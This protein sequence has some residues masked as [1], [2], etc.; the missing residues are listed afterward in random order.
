MEYMPNN[1]VIESIYPITSKKT[2]MMKIFT[3]L[4]FLLLTVYGPG[5]LAQT[6]LP[7][8][9]GFENVGTTTTFTSATTNING[10]SEWSYEKTANGRVRFAA[11]SAY[12]R[13]GSHAAT[14]DCSRNFTFSNNFLILTLDLDAYK[15]S[16][17]ELDFYF[18][19][20]GDER[21]NGQDKVWVR[22]SNTSSWVQIYD[23]YA[24]RAGNGQWK[25]SGSLDIDAVLSNANQT[26]GKTFQVRFGQR[27]NYQATSTTA[28]DGLTI[29]DLRIVEVLDRNG[30]I[31]DI[32]PFCTGTSPVQVELSNLGNNTITSAKISWWVDGVAQAGYTFTGSVAKNNTANITLGNYNFSSTSH[33]FK[34]VVDSINGLVDQNVKDTLI[35]AKDPA[36]SGAFTVGPN[37]DFSTPDRAVIAMVDRGICGPVSFTIDY[38]TYSGRMTIPAING[39]SSTN[40]ITFD[41][42]DSSRT[43]ITYNAAARYPTLQIN[44]GEYIT[45]KNCRL[46]TTR[47]TDGWCAHVLGNSHHISFENCWFDMPAQNFDLIG[48]VLS[49]S[50]TSEFTATRVSHVKAVNSRFTGGEK[51]IHF[52]GNTNPFPEG[53]SAINNTF[54][55]FYNAAIDVRN[56]DSFTVIGNHVTST[57]NANGDGFMFYDIDDFN[58]SNNFISVR[59]WGLYINDANFN[60]QGRS[61]LSNNMVTAGDDGIYLNDI[62]NTDVWHNTAIGRPGILFDDYRGVDVRNNIFY[63][64]NDFALSCDQNFGFDVLDYNL[65]YTTGNNTARYANVNYTS[66]DAWRGAVT[67]FNASS[68]E[69]V[70]NI[71]SIANPRLSLLSE[72]YRGEYLAAVSTDIDGDSRCAFAPSLGADE[73]GFPT[74]KTQ[75]FYASP[76]TGYVNSSTSFDNRAKSTD[77]IL[78]RWLVDG[79]QEAS[80]TDF[81]YKFASAGTYIVDLIS[82]GCG[83]IDTFS[84]T[85]VITIPSVRPTAAFFAST[86]D[87]DVNESVDFTNISSS[88]ADSFYWV[89]DSYWVTG[90][91]GLKVKSH[92]FING[93]DS[94]SL[95]PTIEFTSPG[96]YRICLYAF[97]IRGV[98][99]VCKAAHINVRQRVDMCG[100]ADES[101]RAYGKL[102]DNGGPLGNYANNLTCGFLV[103]PCTDEITLNFNDFNLSGGDFLRIYDGKDNTAPPLHNYHASYA[104]GLT[105][106]ISSANFK[107]VLTA[108]SG[109]VYFEFQSNNTGNNRGFNIDWTSQ[110]LNPAKPTVNFIVPDSICTGVPFVTDNRTTGPDV[111]YQ[112]YMD[113]TN[114]NRFTDL[115]SDDLNTTHEYDSARTYHVLLVASG[116]GVLDSALKPITV[117]NPTT[118]PTS[119]FAINNRRPSIGDTVSLDDLSTWGRFDCITQHEWIISPNTYGFVAGFDKNSINPQIL[120]TDTGCY[121]ISLV[122]TNG[123]GSDTF[124][125]NCGVYSISTCLPSVKIPSQ[126]FGITRVAV[127]DIDNSSTVDGTGYQ[128]HVNAGSTQLEMGA[129]YQIV[130]ERPNSGPRL[131]RRAVWIDY[132]MDGTFDDATEKVTSSGSD[133]NLSWTGSFK[134]PFNLREG[135]TRLRVGVNHGSFTNYGCG[136]NRF[137]EFEDY[138]V[139]ISSDK[140]AP[141][142]FLM[143]AS[144]TTIQ[145]CSGWSDPGAFA[146]DNVNGRVSISSMFN[147]IDTSME[148]SYSVIYRAKDSLGNEG[149]VTRTVRVMQD[150]TPPVI[151]LLGNTTM[152]LEVFDTYTEPGFTVSDNCGGLTTTDVITNGIPNVNTLGL[153]EI[154]YLLDDQSGNSVS[155]K[156]MVRVE[157]TQSPSLSLIGQDTVW[158]EVGTPY[159]ELGVNWSDNY[160]NDLEVKLSGIVDVYQ[161]GT[162]KITYSIEDGSGNKAV[163]VVR[164]IIVGDGTAPEIKLINQT[165]TVIINVLAE[166][167]EIEDFFVTDNYDDATSIEASLVTSGTYFPRFGNGATTELGLYNV[168]YTVTDNAGNMASAERWIKVVDQEA[169]VINFNGP[170]V[171]TIPRWGFYDETAVEAID[172]Y[173]EQSEITLTSSGTVDKNKVGNYIITYCAKDP[174]GNES[175]AERTIVVAETAETVGLKE[176]DESD[177][178]VYPNPTREFLT[179]EANLST[180]QNLQISVVDMMGRTVMNLTPQNADHLETTINVSTLESGPYMVLVKTN[181]AVVVKKVTVER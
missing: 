114:L 170:Q 32:D 161:V 81:T 87:I 39:S 155:V 96:T 113:T 159:T 150:T 11:G 177:V 28:S 123:A 171:V 48:I 26:I 146:I 66:L 36:M 7:F 124:T 33:D 58:V 1:Q 118:R 25:H 97:N 20:H 14:L 88:G 121:D 37:G 99:T 23:W 117:V 166:K 27:D 92:Q 154:E 63:G 50:A 101:T 13:T 144:D 163:D 47:S 133:Q 179:I 15:N 122:T 69:D 172:N 17:L 80:T 178:S 57:R 53:N 54:D 61:L 46:Q 125:W 176:I 56:Q 143:G 167:Y 130:I 102:F 157:D 151:T 149:V 137:G 120:L 142:V 131:M 128:N 76:D 139:F 44:G 83:G 3:P 107:T 111:S 43:T 94:N 75:A 31:T 8:I 71:Q 55:N 18:M 73:S 147:G 129:T 108:I 174:S 156:R 68:L 35:Q 84:R 85:I 100:V 119:A 148:G 106:D 91:F 5:L 115:K 165:D 41:G 24:N 132:N 74:P 22:G 153:Y 70:P 112:W 67:G 30:V 162:Y 152:S 105:G 60:G 16:N 168:V 19:H 181:N 138:R 64:L 164:Y 45:F 42:Q 175:C 93:T 21:H 2:M 145:K 29:D 173:Y 140:T 103:D 160:D 126:N 110:P 90:D 72:S 109:E 59:D 10:L 52:Q 79:K 49:N 89:V 86:T 116:C 51:G 82:E 95:N 180:S 40:T 38:G 135:S 65:Y 12:N 9:E 127:G 141:E 158:L 169:P 134:V 77:P 78:H 6:S 4:V 98:D 104:N 34:V 62:R 136:P